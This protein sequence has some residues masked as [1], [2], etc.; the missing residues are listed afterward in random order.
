MGLLQQQQLLVV[1]SI[2]GI[3]LITRFKTDEALTI[4]VNAQSSIEGIPL[5]TR[6][7]TLLFLLFV[8]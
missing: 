5:I 3:P 7:K 8:L 2:E 4:A 6:F 1:R